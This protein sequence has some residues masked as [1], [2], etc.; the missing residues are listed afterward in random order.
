MLYQNQN[1]QDKVVAYASR[2]LR[3]SGKNYPVHK[4]EFL[5]F[6]WS[7]TEKFHDYLYGTNFE[8]LTDNNPLTYA[9][10][11]AK[12]YATGHRRLAE[13]SNYNFTIKYRSGKKHADADGLSRLLENDKTTTVFPD[14]LKAICQT[15]VVQKDTEP[16][17]DSLVDPTLA[18][19]CHRLGFGPLEVNNTR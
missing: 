2:G 16:L 11:T 5:A 10:T 19:I 12:L 6:K 13:L 18:T 17:A 9:P 7:V 15:V 14:I 8:V 1:G 4:L 3:P